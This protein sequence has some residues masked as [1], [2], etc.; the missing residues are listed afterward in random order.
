MKGQGGFLPQITKWKIPAGKVHLLNKS[1]GIKFS[2][3]QKHADSTSPLLLRVARGKWIAQ[4]RQS[5]G[6]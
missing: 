6:Q 3:R 4:H 5:V 1:N 2:K